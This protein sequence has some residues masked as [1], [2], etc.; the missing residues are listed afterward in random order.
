MRRL[1]SQIE[2]ILGYDFETRRRIG[3]ATE[4]DVLDSYRDL[5]ASASTSTS[6]EDLMDAIAVFLEAFGEEDSEEVEALFT[7]LLKTQVLSDEVKNLVSRAV[8]ESIRKPRIDGRQLVESMEQ[9][10]ALH[11]NA[12]KQVKMAR[13]FPEASQS[14]QGF[15]DALKGINQE[16]G[17]AVQEDLIRA[18]IDALKAPEFVKGLKQYAKVLIQTQDD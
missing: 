17:A 14:Q 5:I 16:V 1:N 4:D 15:I 10:Q 13:S 7:A 2:S 11:C 18:M 8:Q 6:L 3:E 12:H 9:L